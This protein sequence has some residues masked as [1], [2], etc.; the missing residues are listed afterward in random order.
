MLTSLVAEPRFLIVFCHG[1]LGFSHK[2]LVGDY[3]RGIVTKFDEHYHVIAP[4][5]SP[6]GSIEDRACELNEAIEGWF[7][8]PKNDKKTTGNVHLIG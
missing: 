7:A 8:N 1:V 4:Q 5:V 3:F 2:P 6:V